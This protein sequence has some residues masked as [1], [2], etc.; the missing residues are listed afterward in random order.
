[1]LLTANNGSIQISLTENRKGFAQRRK[2][3]KKNNEKILVLF[4]RDLI[5]TQYLIPS[6]QYPVPN[7]LRPQP[8][9]GDVFFTEIGLDDIFV[10][11]Y[12]LRFPLCDLLAEIEHTDPV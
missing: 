10:V 9:V 4:E 8:G 5:S 6:P 11:S 7:T 1:M 3:A 2:G 12:L